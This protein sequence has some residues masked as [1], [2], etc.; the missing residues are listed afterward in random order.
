M[1]RARDR[2][3]HGLRGP[4]MPATLPGAISRRQRF[5]RS[6][7]EVVAEFGTRVPEVHDIDVLVEDVPAV[8]AKATRIPLGRVVRHT[9]TPQLVIHRR[10]IEATG[11]G[12]D[13][14]RDVLAEIAGDL[15]IRP[16]EDFD[17]GYPHCL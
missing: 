14:V 15:L 7:A 1:R 5:D 16:P 9:A 3:G 13:L 17:P 2:H 11:S 8:P 12:T 10:A 6:V 4:L